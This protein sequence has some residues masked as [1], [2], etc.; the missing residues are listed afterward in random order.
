MY[1]WRSN[2]NMC[3]GSVIMNFNPQLF[4]LLSDQLVSQSIAF[5]FIHDSQ[6]RLLSI[7]SKLALVSSIP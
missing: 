7:I 2:E 6:C 3:S 5:F 4:L 1:Y